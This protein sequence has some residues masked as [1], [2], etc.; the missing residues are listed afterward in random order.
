M[1]KV[2]IDLETAIEIARGKIR[3]CEYG[4]SVDDLVVEVGW[5]MENYSFEIEVEE[6]E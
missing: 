6:D 4:V 2:V 1:K 5:A 3:D